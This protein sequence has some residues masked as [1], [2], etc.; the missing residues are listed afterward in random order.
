MQT[1]ERVDR[2]A[3]LMARRD[4]IATDL[5]HSESKVTSLKGE[6]LSVNAELS[7]LIVDE[8]APPP[9]PASGR[10]CGNCQQVGHSAKTCPEPKRS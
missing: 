5:V 1:Q 6:R 7:Q 3:K 4:E 9:E 8:G 2:I 10:K